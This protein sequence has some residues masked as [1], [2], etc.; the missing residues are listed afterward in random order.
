MPECATEEFAAQARKVAD[1]LYKPIGERMEVLET[2]MAAMEEKLFGNFGK[3]IQ[4]NR[5][6]QS[7]NM[8]MVGF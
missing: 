7:W 4:R 1:G 2:K 6:G 5:Y 8:D 3:S